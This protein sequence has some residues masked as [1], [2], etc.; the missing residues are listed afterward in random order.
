MRKLLFFIVV[1]CFV[2]C[3]KSNDVAPTIKGHLIEGSSK[4]SLSNVKVT[5]FD[6][7]KIYAIVFSDND[8]M[9]SMATPTLEDNHYY[10]LSFFWSDAYPAK[11]ITIYNAPVVLELNDVIVY[12]ETNPYGYELY[13]FEGTSYMIHATLPG[14]FTFNEAKN[15]C[16]SLRDG[17]DDWM[18]PP[19]D[20]MD[21]IADDESFAKRIAEDGW[22]WSS[23]IT[24]G[25]NVDYYTCVN[26]INNDA[27]YS[28]NPNERLKVL[29][30]RIVK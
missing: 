14:L 20:L 12:D 16:S 9:F 26:I 7:I 6:D 30:V 28:T 8:G 18:L 24:N 4:K 15:S 23:W 2:G 5:L 13:T 1:L 27:G 25:N 11:I 22:Y 29:P 3:V 19:A 17:Y 21:V 10:K